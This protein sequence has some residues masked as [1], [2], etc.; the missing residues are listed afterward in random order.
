MWSVLIVIL[1]LGHA[2]TVAQSNKS[3]VTEDEC[4]EHAPEILNTVRASFAA[5]LGPEVSFGW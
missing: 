5:Q 4:V 2:P 1:I 3:W